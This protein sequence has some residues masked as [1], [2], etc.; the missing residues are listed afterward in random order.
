M[1]LD[2]EVDMT[3]SHHFS[4][5]AIGGLQKHDRNPQTWSDEV[6]IAIFIR[7]GLQNDKQ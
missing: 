6:K 2:A 3:A 7:V 5:T 1:I 4:E